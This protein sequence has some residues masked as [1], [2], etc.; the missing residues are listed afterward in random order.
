MRLHNEKAHKDFSHYTHGF[1]FPC[2]IILKVALEF[3]RH[4]DQLRHNP[5]FWRAVRTNPKRL[6]VYASVIPS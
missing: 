4:L 6:V 3:I 1:D 5:A 2:W